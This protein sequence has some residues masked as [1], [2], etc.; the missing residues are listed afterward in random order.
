MII[1]RIKIRNYKTYLS[2]DLDLTVS[3]ER[4]IILIGGQ[5]G[6]GKT[7]LFEAICGVLYGLKIQ[8]KEQFTEL[9]N[10]GARGRE[11]PKIEIELYFSG[12]VLSSTK[13]YVMRRTYILNN[14]GKP[15]E[16]VML[17]MDGTI[18]TYGSASSARDRAEGEQQVNKIIRA[19]LPEELSKY[20]L[21]DAMQTSELMKKNVF[22]QIIQD[23]IENVMGFKKFVQ[24]RDCSERV[25]QGWAQRR[26]EAQQEAEAYDRLCEEKKALQKQREQNSANQ[27]TI[28]RYLADIQDLYNAAKNGAAEAEAQRNKLLQIT[29][30]IKT[31]GERAD[32]FCEELKSFVEEIEQ[33]VF[34]SHLAYAMKEEI[35]QIAHLREAVRKE[36]ENSYSADMLRD[37]THRLLQYMQSLSLC[38]PNIDEQ[39]IV[40][41]LVAEQQSLQTGDPYSYLDNIE[42]ENL[43]MLQINN[44][45]NS[46]PSL[47]RMR[48]D[49][50]DQ[51]DDL[52]NLNRQKA[53]LE[54]SLQQGNE[55]LIKDYEHRKHLLEQLKS[56]AQEIES[57]I[58]AI[59]N[60]IHK[61]DIQI[62]QEPDPRYDTL[63]KLK[64]IFS[65]ISSAL[66]KRKKTQI[67][68]EMKQQLNN[69][70]LAYKGCIERVELS[71]TLEQ[72]NIRLFH[73]HGNEI[74]L[75]NLNAAS[76]QIFIQV[77]LKVLRN[78][79]DYNP[80]VMIDTVM[81]VLD[82][83]SRDALMEHYFP[84]LST[85][86]ILLCTTSE[87]RKEKDYERLEPFIAKTYTLVRNVEEQCTAVEEGYFG[88]PLDLT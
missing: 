62:Q 7:T 11:A 63:V 19:N 6:G 71:D 88:V 12:Q 81:G 61:F 29:N 66:L 15:V 3:D 44:S 77:L 86:T 74:S 78:L 4:S 41:H 31:I 36:Q 35:E 43:S 42:V 87:I 26:L 49:I 53:S 85:Q 73:T 72:F 2:L 32:N 25:Q 10:D 22:A 28:Y 59:D 17:N 23:N 20:F 80:P 67:E 58:K 14:S 40:D 65:E 75:T 84:H 54:S 70:L 24:L 34:L 76:K 1:Q 39:N 57:K 50:N 16:S 13:R 45:Y 46:F 51:L 83:A 37:I 38:V 69:L 52:E 27:D 68:A 82:E 8:S 5:N 47:D 9:L 18:F 21:F 33:N 48:Q 60:K 55:E 30:Q 64:T 79:G 56:E